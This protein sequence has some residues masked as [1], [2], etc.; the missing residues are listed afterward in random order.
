MT[1]SGTPA[2]Y[3]YGNGTIVVACRT[4]S[5]LAYS[6]DNGATWTQAQTVSGGIAGV[7]FHIN[8]FVACTD[9]GFVYSST[10]GIN[11]T[12]FQIN[13][14]AGFNCIATNGARVIVGGASGYVYWSTTGMAASGQWTIASTVPTS[15]SYGIAWNGS[16]FAIATASGTAQSIW[17]SP[18]G[19]VWTNR[20]HSLTTPSNQ[21]RTMGAAGSIFM[22]A[23]SSNTQLATSTDG[24]TWTNRTLTH[25]VVATVGGGGLCVAVGSSAELSTS[26]DNGVN[27]TRV[28]TL[29]GSGSISN[30]YRVSLL[31]GQICI[32]HSS[33][34]YFS[35]F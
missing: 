16:L 5:S 8:Q 35:N 12:S 15:P 26:V 24:V 19:A 29:S 9:V 25:D 33:G 30:T 14:S 7:V 4:N 28:G 23:N 32:P 3:A 1:P 10:D 13:V 17:T 18:D 11:W 34:K 2:Q 6:L 22:V 31:A 27:W 21:T 20:T